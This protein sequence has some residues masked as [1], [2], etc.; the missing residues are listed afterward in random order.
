MSPTISEYKLDMDDSFGEQGL[1]SPLR[2]QISPLRYSDPG[3]HECW[4]I[5][6]LQ[7]LLWWSLSSI[8]DS[9]PSLVSI[10]ADDWSLSCFYLIEVLFGFFVYMFSIPRINQKAR[11]FIGIVVVCC[12]IWGCLTILTNGIRRVFGVHPA[13]VYTA[14]ALFAGSLGV[15]HHNVHRQDYLLDQLL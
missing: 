5:F 10:P 11:K 15:F 7:F 13:I 3:I 14:T 8:F 6:T 9:I 12:G 4:Y 2:K 1:L